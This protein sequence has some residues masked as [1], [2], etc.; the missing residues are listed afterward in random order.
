M[1]AFLI[2]PVPY[3]VNLVLVIADISGMCVKTTILTKYNKA[4]T[5]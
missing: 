5:K 4:K 3:M 1:K 2:T